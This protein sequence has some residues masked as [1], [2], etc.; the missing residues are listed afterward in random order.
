[1]GKGSGKDRG[2]GAASWTSQHGK[3]TAALPALAPAAAA[4]LGGITL[5]Q[6]KGWTVPGNWAEGR[7]SGYM[8]RPSPNAKSAAGWIR[9]LDDG[10]DVYFQPQ[11]LDS[12]LADLLRQGRL[13]HTRVSVKVYYRPNGKERYTREVHYLEEEV[14]VQGGVQRGVSGS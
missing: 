12:S 9:M 10:P 3:G 4:E 1:M 8:E 5:W 14:D 7:V 13:Q 11:Q 6:T 2:A